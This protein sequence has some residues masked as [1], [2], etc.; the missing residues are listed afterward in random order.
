VDWRGTA[1]AALRAPA[2]PLGGWAFGRLRSGASQSKAPSPCGPRFAP[3]MALNAPANPPRP[4]F[5]RS[6]AAL[7]HPVGSTHGRPE[8]PLRHLVEGASVGSTRSTRTAIAPSGG[9]SLGRVDPWST[10]IAMTPSGGRSL[11]RVD[12]WSTR[13]A[14]TP[15]GGRSIGRVDPWSTRTAITPSGG[16]SL[17]RVD[18]WS[19]RTAITPSGGGSPLARGGREAAGIRHW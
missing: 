15:S 2:Q 12:P 6:T 10:R 11:G 8:S 18:P 17:G 19:T 5:D 13:T 3:S 7:G 16:R 9:R 1:R 14:I 4:T